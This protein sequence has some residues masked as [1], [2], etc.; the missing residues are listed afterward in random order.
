MAKRQ[1]PQ[2]VAVFDFDGT[3][4]DTASIFKII[5]ADIA[6]KNNW[7]Y[8][9]EEEFE[10]LRKGTIR[11]AR[12]WAGI[13]FWKLP[14]LIHDVKK[15]MRRDADKVVLFPEVVELIRDLHKDGFAI[16]ILSRN[17]PETIKA[18]LKRY[19]VDGKVQII[20][21]KKR[22]LDSKSIPLILLLRRNKYDRKYVWMIGD[23]VRD[24]LSAKRAGVHSVAVTW[25]L[26]DVS[27]LKKYRPTYLVKN[28][29]ELRQILQQ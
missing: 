16:Y 18:V 25:G 22:Y 23:E 19:G 8:P 6:D 11:D 21:R 28:V 1:K 27:I 3:L 17:L 10:N 20:R 12:K 4:A 26:Q 29:A 2:K 7:K 9:T 5:Y 13:P 15:V 14:F 24:I